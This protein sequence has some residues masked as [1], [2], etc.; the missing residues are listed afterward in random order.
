[1]PNALKQCD[2]GIVIPAYSEE[3]RIGSTLD[4]LLGFLT[5]DPFLAKLNTE[6]LVVVADSLDQ[7][8]RIVRQK[9]VHYAKK[10][11]PLRLLTPGPKVGKGRDVQFGILHA[12][13]DA[14]LYMDA[15]LAT[16]LHHIPQC[17]EALQ[18]GADIVIG[19]RDLMKY[20]NG[21]ARNLFARFGNVLYRVAGGLRV[22]DTQCGF[23]LF[24]R[25]AAQLCFSRLTI[26]GWGFDI[27][28]L[29]IAQTH[30]LSIV[31]HRIDDWK[32]MPFSTYTD[33]MLKISTRSMRDMAKITWNRFIGAYR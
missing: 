31:A 33:S 26:L 12:D 17:Y 25:D 11:I 30:K 2:L 29:A 24:K 8:H 20:R 15:D 3:L 19:T 16:P 23:K 7:T 9:A 21:Y 10:N 28:V 27:E 1:M 13:S 5:T 22:E 6:V 32:D 4:Q 18:Q 14:I